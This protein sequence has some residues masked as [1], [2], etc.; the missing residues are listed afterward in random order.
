MQITSLKNCLPTFKFFSVSFF[1]FF[2]FW[3]SWHKVVPR[4]RK[5]EP[6]IKVEHKFANIQIAFLCKLQS[7][8][9]I[10]L[11][12]HSMESKQ[13][14]TWRGILLIRT[15][16]LKVIN[17]GKKKF[18]PSWNYWS[19]CRTNWVGDHSSTQI[20]KIVD[21]SELTAAKFLIY[22]FI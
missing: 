10:V 17:N 9:N 20:I 6:Q 15:F 3:L 13:K 1:P 11:R 12:D 7:S 16:V 22:L 4:G 18:N 5:F 21:S 14:R 2:F 19:Y 8:L